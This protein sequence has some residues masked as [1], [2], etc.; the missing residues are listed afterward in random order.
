VVVAGVVV[1]EAAE[2]ICPASCDGRRTRSARLATTRGFAGNAAAPAGAFGSE[3]SPSV[4]DRLSRGQ[5]MDPIGKSLFDE[6]RF[7]FRRRHHG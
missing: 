7:R 5:V 1:V 2:E 6:F 3:T 4:G